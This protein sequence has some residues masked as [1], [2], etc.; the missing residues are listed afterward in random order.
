MEREIDALRRGCREKKDV[1]KSVLVRDRRKEEN[2]WERR[3][4][5]HADSKHRS[6]TRSGRFLEFDH[7]SAVLCCCKPL[8][9]G[10][11]VSPRGLSTVTDRLR[12][13]ER[14]ACARR[15]HLDRGIVSR[16]KSVYRGGKGESTK[17]FLCLKLHF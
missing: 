5:L 11:M 3:E 16:R 10:F 13:C 12:G 7:F 6:I 17:L 2:I 8:I 14:L 15:T 4:A 1:T 9:L